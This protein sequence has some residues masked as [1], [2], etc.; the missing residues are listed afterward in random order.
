MSLASAFHIEA[1]IIDLLQG[2]PAN[3]DQLIGTGPNT[4][5][6]MN[7]LRQTDALPAVVM[8]RVA[9]VDPKTHDGTSG[10]FQA[11]IDFSCIAESSSDAMQLASRLQ[12]GLDDL[13][14]EGVNITD[15]PFVYRVVITSS[16]HLS[17][18]DDPSFP[19]DATD[20][21]RYVRVVRIEFSYTSAQSGG[22]LP[23]P[24]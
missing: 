18:F 14:N 7:M 20:T 16:E 4:R 23:Q 17:T 8:E 22:G 2:N 12:Q 24:S 13:R 21:P 19:I 5:V 10:L 11:T 3:I 15:G 6:R 9:T 1:A